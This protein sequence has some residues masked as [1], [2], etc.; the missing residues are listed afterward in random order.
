MAIE[1]RAVPWQYDRRKHNPFRCEDLAM[2]ESTR[3]AHALTLAAL[4]LFGAAGC[5]D[6][7]PGISVSI[8]AQFRDSAGESVDLGKAYEAAWDRVCVFGPYTGNGAVRRSLGFEWNADGKSVIRSNDGIALLLF[9]RAKEVVAYAEHP[10][11]LGDFANQSGKCFA[12]ERAR[13][14]QRRQ[15]SP[16]GP[17]GMYP[18]DG[19]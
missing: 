10:R 19:P 9:V 6:S 1:I 17:A 18:K 2:N 12:R 14:Y 13:F 16:Q 4:L 5:H 7:S 15:A 11:N 8:A 3:M